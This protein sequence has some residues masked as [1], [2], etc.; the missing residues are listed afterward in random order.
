MSIHRYILVSSLLAA[1]LIA[2]PTMGSA[3]VDPS[4]NGCRQLP[5]APINGKGVDERLSVKLKEL[6][7]CKIEPGLL[8]KS[9]ASAPAGLT[10]E[11]QASYGR[12]FARRH[13]GSLPGLP[14]RRIEE[15]ASL[16]APAAPRAPRG[17][18]EQH[19]RDHVQEQLHALPQVQYADRGMDDSSWRGKVTAPLKPRGL[20]PGPAIDKPSFTFPLKHP[21]TQGAH[22]RDGPPSARSR[23]RLV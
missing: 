4:P 7:A 17:A 13:S 3:A 12:R 15:G 5:S 18:C 6:T 9:K 22:G 21:S 2:L 10:N 8:A 23:A 14:R 19:L 1:T 11:G 20:A 16:R